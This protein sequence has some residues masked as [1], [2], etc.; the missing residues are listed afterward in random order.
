MEDVEHAAKERN[1]KIGVSNREND[2]RLD[3]WLDH[4][5][6]RLYAAE[7]LAMREEFRKRLGS[8][9]IAYLAACRRRESVAFREAGVDL[10]SL[11]LERAGLDAQSFPWPP[12]S[13]RNRVPYRGLNSLDAQDAGIFFGRD[14]EIVRALS[15]IR[16]LVES[17]NEKLLIILGASGVGKSSFL[18]AGLW[19]RLARYEAAFLP[20]RIIEPEFG[21]IS[22]ESGLA[23]ALSEAFERFGARRTPMTS[24]THWPKTHR[25]LVHCSMERRSR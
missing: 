19:P 23:A 17:G 18:R 1:Q 8:I 15:R 5:G 2:K 9:G 22:G 16:S 6:E 10:L 20:L 25:H 12:P 4:R 14:E 7:K 21:V 13:E 11:G 3:T 24:G